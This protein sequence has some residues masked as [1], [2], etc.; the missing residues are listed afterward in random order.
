MEDTSALRG[1]L[2][3]AGEWERAIAEGQFRT[4]GELRTALRARIDDMQSDLS[5]LSALNTLL[6][7]ALSSDSSLPF[8]LH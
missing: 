2:A 4:L 3:E 1:R 8:L 5:A 6:R 7:P